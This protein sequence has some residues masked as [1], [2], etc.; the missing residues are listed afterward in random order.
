MFARWLWNK[1]TGILVHLPLYKPFTNP[2]PSLPA[3]CDWA[4]SPASDNDR[5]RPRQKQQDPAVCTPPEASPAV[6]PPLLSL[7]LRAAGRPR[8]PRCSRRRVELPPVR[9]PGRPPQPPGLPEAAPGGGGGVRL[10]QRPR[11]P[12]HSLR[13]APFRGGPQL[14]LRRRRRTLAR[15]QTASLVNRASRFRVDD[16]V[17][18]SRGDG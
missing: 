11:P 17:R 16:S 14:R 8:R 18:Y 13:R 7:G 6:A 2:S 10:R 15:V 4:T 9:R 3:V 5:R 12:R 1:M